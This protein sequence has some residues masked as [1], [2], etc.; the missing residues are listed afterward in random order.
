MADNTERVDDYI[1]S[2]PPE[3]QAILTKIREL[4]HAAVPEATESVR[5]GMPAVALGDGYRLYFAA[6]KRHVGLYPIAT[7]TEPLEGELMRYRSGKDTVRFP[8]A[9]PIPYPVVERLVAA[10]AAEH[11]IADQAS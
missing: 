3:V 7:L 1:A 6:W 10:I 9:T 11:A 2:H 5:Y 4:I 8:L